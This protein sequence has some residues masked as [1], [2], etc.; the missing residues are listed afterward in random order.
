MPVRC[1]AA[2]NSPL[3]SRT[4]LFEAVAKG[5]RN[6]IG[7][8]KRFSVKEVSN[9]TGVPDRAIECAKLEPDNPDWRVLSAEQLV[10]LSS[11]LGPVFTSEWLAVAQQG[12][13]WLPDGE[14]EPGEMAADNADDNAVITRAARDN[15][16]DQL[17][18]PQ[19]RLVG[20]HLIERGERL[21]ALGGR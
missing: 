16:F 10:S 12:A 14:I 18:R 13:F 20:E 1:N 15:D 19:L 4:K 7:R 5:L 3:V 9:H 17:E 11:F 8:G 21:V 6:E 2:N